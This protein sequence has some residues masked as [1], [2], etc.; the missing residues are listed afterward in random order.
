MERRKRILLYCHLVLGLGHLM[1]TLRIARALAEDPEVDCRV[2][3]G[4]SK[5]DHIAI[6]DNVGLF[7]L[8]AAHF[9]LSAHICS[10]DGDPNIIER[11]RAL[12][13]QICRDWQPDVVL[14]DYFPHGFGGELIDV[15]QTAMDENW[16]TRFVWGI[17]YGENAFPAPKNPRMRR[18]VLHYD[19]IIAYAEP[20]FLDPMPG[21]AHYPTPERVFYAGIVAERPPQIQMASPPVVAGLT[22]SGVGGE[23]I[24]NVLVRVMEE[25]RRTVPARL[26]FVVGLHGDPA[27][28]YRT[29]AERSWIEI[30]E[31]GSAEAA[32]QD[33]SAVVSRTGYNSS[34]SLIQTPLPLVFVPARTNY[35]RGEQFERARALAEFPHVWMVDERSETLDTDLLHAVRLALESGLTERKLPFRVNGASVAAGY[36]KSLARHEAYA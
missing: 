22:G 31:E 19:S 1:R 11:R 4:G 33:A 23:M 16:P 28:F 12:A 36:L 15:F 2:L 26:R 21:F 9:T 7:E 35:M 6:P 5:L 24:F 20:H 14:V 32:V 25:I 30:W 10:E 17:P 29:A 34:F 3:T 13:L 18:S 8:P 27:P